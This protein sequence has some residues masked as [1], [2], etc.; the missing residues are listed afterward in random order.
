M[1]A[2]KKLWCKYKE[3]IL[4][5]F[6]GAGTTFVNIVSYFIFKY[7]SLSVAAS[8]VFSWAAAVCFAYVTNRI[9]VFESSEK[10]LYAVLKEFS[11]FTAGRIFTGLIDLAIMV[12]CV[13]MLHFNEPFMKIVSNVIVIILNYIISKLIVFKKNR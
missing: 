12:V 11:S 3:M 1:E 9:Y 10:G 2:L 5:M 13:D 4:Y 6:F 7:L 8:S